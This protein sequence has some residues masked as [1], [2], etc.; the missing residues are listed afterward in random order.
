MIK[1]AREYEGG[2]DLQDLER[3]VR[4]TNLLLKNPHWLR[5]LKEGLTVQEAK[6]EEHK[7]CDY[8]YLG[9]QWWECRG[10]PHEL[11]ALVCE[12]L[13]DVSFSSNS[14]TYYKIKNPKL[15]R[16]AIEIVKK[17]KEE[18]I[19]KEEKIPRD[20]FSIIVGY[21]NIKWILTAS[22]KSKQPVHVLLVGPPSTAK[23]LFLSE[24]SRLPNSRYILGS[25]S[26]RAG[27]IDYLLEARPVY[28]IIDELEKADGEGLSAL[29]SL[30]QTGIVT[31]LKK[32][33]RERR[34]LKTWVFAGANSI[35]RVPQEL[36]SRF[37]IIHFKEYTDQEFR[38]V[39]SSLL[40][41]EGI[42]NGHKDYII[43]KVLPYTKDVRDV[44]KTG[45]LAKDKSEVDKIVRV[46]F[47]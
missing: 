32:R 11:R 42:K 35:K 22:L 34:V 41:R 9:F 29:L 23:T 2:T 40:E 46:M 12:G 43:D 27:I 47:K 19:P 31:R 33:M 16:Q 3:K 39:A 1:G 21:Q 24:L 13:L 4:T 44:L 20:L 7:N 30:M 8:P 18:E 6:Q 10:R 37:L 28:L 17:G 5:I 26:S 45:R 15:L 38:R 36:K 25:A 14:S